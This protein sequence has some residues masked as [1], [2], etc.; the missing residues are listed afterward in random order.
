MS[1][2]DMITGLAPILVAKNLDET[3]SFYT[4][5]LGFEVDFVFK[6]PGID[7]YA[8]LCLEGFRVNFREGSSPGEPSSFG[9]ISIEVVDVDEFYATLVKRDA[10][11]T[12]F[13]RQ[14][15]CIREHPP[16]DK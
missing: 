14:F 2:R 8:S 1:K 11:P 5:K 9:G 12:D 4:E 16:E 3:V 13:P 15:S 7:G 6:E 10:L